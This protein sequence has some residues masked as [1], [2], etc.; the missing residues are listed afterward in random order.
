MS[1]IKLCGLNF[2]YESQRDHQKAWKEGWVEV[3]QKGSH[4][5]FKK[6]GIPE[7][8]VLPDHGKNHELSIGVMMD[9]IK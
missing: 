8:I 1:K 5:I 3:R 4:R 9:I 6:T 2:I 7:L